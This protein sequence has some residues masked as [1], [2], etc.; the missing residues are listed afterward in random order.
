MKKTDILI[1]LVIEYAI[2]VERKRVKRRM[3]YTTI[4]FDSGVKKNV[5]IPESTTKLE[6]YVVRKIIS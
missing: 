6:R 1:S 4:L 3:K 2:R 5:K